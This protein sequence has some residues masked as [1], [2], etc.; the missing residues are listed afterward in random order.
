MKFTALLPALLVLAACASPTA[1]IDKRNFNCGE[2]GHE[3]SI[4]AGFEDPRVSESLE[5]RAFLVEVANNAHEEITV[6]TVRVE[7][8]SKNH[9][10]YDTAVTSKDV[11]I[12]EG[13]AH[14]FRMPARVPLV[15]QPQMD[16]SE[17]RYPRQLLEFSVTVSLT[18]GD[19]YRCGFVVRL[20]D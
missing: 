18:N 14:V 16:R 4:A 8:S 3:V 7:P 5:E 1:V 9:I 2:G 17:T 11:V 13:E 19:D 15:P 12:A 20:D 10:R 6:T